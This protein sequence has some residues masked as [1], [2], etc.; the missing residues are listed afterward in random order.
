MA[1]IEAT[2]SLVGLQNT[3]FSK[4]VAELVHHGKKAP[5]TGTVAL[6]LSW[7]LALEVLSLGLLGSLL[8]T[9]GLKI[10]RLVL[11]RVKIRN[12]R[13]FKNLD[14][15]SSST[16]TTTNTVTDAGTEVEL[17]TMGEEEIVAAPETRPAETDGN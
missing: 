10:L 16:T 3:S 15:C 2:H 13:G 11:T 8:A 6:H 12:Q 14:T 9:A 1:K 5:T 7:Q 17:P 4:N